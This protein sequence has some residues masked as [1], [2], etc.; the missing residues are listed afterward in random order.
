MLQFSCCM[1]MKNVVA[2]SMIDKD[3]KRIQRSLQDSVS[4]T[5][6]L[7]LRFKRK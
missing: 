7:K 3:K 4:L 5:E 2:Y 1:L 6:A